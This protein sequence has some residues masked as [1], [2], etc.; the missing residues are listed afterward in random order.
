MISMRGSSNI[1]SHYSSDRSVPSDTELIICGWTASGSTF[2]YQV[3]NELGIKTFKQH[4]YRQAHERA[5]CF[6]TI[7]DPRDVI[8][9]DARRMFRDLWSDGQKEGAVRKALQL[10]IERGFDASYN[11]AVRAT[12]VVIIRY[13]LFLPENPEL[14]IRF[15]ADQFSKPLTREK[16]E[17]IKVHSSIEEN[18]KRSSS[19]K[20][21]SLFYEDSQIHGH[22]ISNWGKIGGWKEFLEPSI[23]NF[24]N[25]ELHALLERTNY[26]NT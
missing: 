18:L 7:R 16:L 26:L 13:E 15:T 24:L 5:L 8:L 25:Q 22:H 6:Y 1:I 4:G 10:F 3:S 12:N 19:L 11:T 17:Q 21:F 20:D 9:S 2:L 14:L 23:Q